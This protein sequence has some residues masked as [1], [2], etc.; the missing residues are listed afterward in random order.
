MEDM[1]TGTCP[2]CSHNE[3]IEAR[4][5]IHGVSGNYEGVSPRVAMTNPSVGFIA[6]FKRALSGQDELPDG[7][8]ITYACRACGFTQT[9]VAGSGRIPIG[10]EHGTRLLHGAEAMGV[11]R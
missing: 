8:W 2:L 7:E 4:P 6:N 11:F 9:F 5:R 1:R 3:I 10:P